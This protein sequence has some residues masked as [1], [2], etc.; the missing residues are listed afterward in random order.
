MSIK[1]P[2]IYESFCD[3]KPVT[4]H[5]ADGPMFVEYRMHNIRKGETMVRYDAIVNGVLRHITLDAD[6]KPERL[7]ALRAQAYEAFRQIETD[8]WTTSPGAATS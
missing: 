5:G 7:P 6:A 3:Q 8:D 1:P 2:P 4:I